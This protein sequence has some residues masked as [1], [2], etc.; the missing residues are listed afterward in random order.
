MDSLYLFGAH[1]ISFCPC[2]YYFF[3]L[4]NFFEFGLLQISHFYLLDCL[5]PILCLDEIVKSILF[6]DIK[7][8]WL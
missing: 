8:V 2:H 6:L 7:S 1:F 4:I 3:I 5:F